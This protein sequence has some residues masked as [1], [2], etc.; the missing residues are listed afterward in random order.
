MHDHL[1]ALLDAG[2]VVTLRSGGSVDQDEYF[3]QV[4]L[5]GGPLLEGEGKTPA[6]ALWN[7][8]PLHGVDE[9]YLGADMADRVKALETD[10]R[11]LSADMSDVFERL[12]AVEKKPILVRAIAEQAD[13]I[14]SHVWWCAKCG[15][16][17]I[18]PEPGNGICRGCGG[19]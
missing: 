7:A 18:G 5:G 10:I 2:Y 4:R 19:A 8:S 17:C 12:D 1:T 14:D 16:E 11:T 6:E 13:V 15:G 9:P 3:A